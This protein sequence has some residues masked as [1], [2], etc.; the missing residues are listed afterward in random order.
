M[1]AS[2]PQGSLIISRIPENQNDIEQDSIITFEQPG[3]QNKFVT[4]RVVNIKEDKMTK[5]FITKGDSN[6]LPDSWTIPFEQVQG[7]YIKHIPY[8]GDVLRHVQS[9][10]GLGLTIL[11]PTVF[12]ILLEIKTIAIILVEMKLQKHDIV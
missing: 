7:L 11:M 4:H 12:L 10:I 6:E 9:P 5:V 1:S 3:Y 2:I 8:V